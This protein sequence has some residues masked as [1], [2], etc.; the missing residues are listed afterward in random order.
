MDLVGLVCAWLFP[1]RSVSGSTSLWWPLNG[2]HRAGELCAHRLWP[3]TCHRHEVLYSGTDSEW[4]RPAGQ[5][6]QQPGTVFA[7]VTWPGKCC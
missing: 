5:G 7:P 3:D 6:M 2:G 4:E 1:L